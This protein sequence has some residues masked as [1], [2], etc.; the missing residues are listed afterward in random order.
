MNKLFDGKGQ[1]KGRI[2]EDTDGSKLFDANSRYRGKY[3]ESMDRT[4][5][6]NGRPFGNGNQLNGLLED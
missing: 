6:E 5:D 4:F 3:V 2:V 1:Y